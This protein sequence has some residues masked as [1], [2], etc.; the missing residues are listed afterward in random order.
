[1]AKNQEKP[2][3]V[4]TYAVLKPLNII[5]QYDVDLIQNVYL[6]DLQF[7]ILNGK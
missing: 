3:L 4:L 1:M 7:K 5:L 2:W 6:K